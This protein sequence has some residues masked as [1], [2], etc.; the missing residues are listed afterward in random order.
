MVVSNNKSMTMINAGEWLAILI[1]IPD[2]AVQRG[3]HC[4]MEHI[5][6][7]TGSHWMPPLGECLHRITPAA[8]MV[9]EFVENTQNTNTIQLLASNYGTFQSLVV[10]ENF[11]PKMGPLL[12]SLIHQA[13]LELESSATFLAIKR[14][15][16]TKSGKVFKLA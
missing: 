13:R 12:S 7:Y 5:Q 9:Y 10:Y 8:A 3:A 15:Q 2:M 16:R 4:L 1:A 11:N 6:G 14:F